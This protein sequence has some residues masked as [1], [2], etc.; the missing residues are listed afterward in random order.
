MRMDNIDA[1]IE[2]F[3][4]DKTDAETGEAI[5]SNIDRAY[6]TLGSYSEISKTIFDKLTQKGKERFY[7]AWAVAGMELAFNWIAKDFDDWDDRKKMSEIFSYNNLSS[8]ENLFAMYSDIKM[9]LSG[10]SRDNVKAV[11]Y[12]PSWLSKN[13]GRDKFV[14]NEWIM[15]FAEKWTSMHSTLKQ[16]YFGGVFRGV[17]EPANP[18]HDFS[19]NSQYGGIIFPFI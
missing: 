11:C 10:E 19:P 1:L 2:L 17:I 3:N 14:G 4:S 18:N 9:C 5:Y 8:I 13:I 15:R 7:I 16:S 12:F 6:N